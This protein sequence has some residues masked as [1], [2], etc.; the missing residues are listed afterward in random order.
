MKLDRKKLLLYAITDRAWTGRQTLYEQVEAALRGGV[1]CLQLREK[2]LDAEEFKREALQIRALCAEYGVPFIINDNVELA[3]SVGA[4]GVHVG[5]SDTPVGQAR[6]YLGPNRIVGATAKTV[7]LARAAQAAGADYLGVGSVF[8]TSTKA[9]A[10]PLP[11]GMLREICAAVSIPVCAIGGI[12]QDNV[13][14]LSASGI[15]GVAVVSAI[16]GAEDI[17]AAAQALRREAERV[18]GQ[19]G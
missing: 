14:L 2:G 3:R 9:D 16:F 5:Q 8:P 6:A 12:T 19:I 7:E 10:V 4:D 11:P 15:A 13:R 17:C 1:T 18:A